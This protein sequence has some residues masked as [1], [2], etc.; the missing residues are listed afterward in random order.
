MKKRTKLIVCILIALIVTAVTVWAIPHI[1]HD[2]I[3]KK[4][5]DKPN[6]IWAGIK[7]VLIIGI[8]DFILIFGPIY[9]IKEKEEEIAQI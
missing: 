8:I 9:W 7:F 5:H 3:Y 4:F 6:I 2:F 1:Y